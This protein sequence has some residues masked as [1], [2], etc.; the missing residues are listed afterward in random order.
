MFI[1]M[2]LWILIEST[3]FS[4]KLLFKSK[5]YNNA[6]ITNFMYYRKTQMS[7]NVFRVTVSWGPKRDKA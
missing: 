7:A 1:F 2:L 3:D 4:I 5:Q 6:N